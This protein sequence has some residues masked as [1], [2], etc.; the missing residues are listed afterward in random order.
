MGY[1]SAHYWYRDSVIS[2]HI[3]M[4]TNMLLLQLALALETPWDVILGI[5][6]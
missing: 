2:Y 1:R 6:L 3:V 5:G 4:Q